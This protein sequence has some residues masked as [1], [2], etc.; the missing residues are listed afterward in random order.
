MII[1]EAVLDD[2]EQLVDVHFSAFSGFFLTSLGRN[3]LI[4]YYKIYI[5]YSHIAFVAEV[6][7]SIEGFVVGSNSS[8]DFYNDLK[9][10]AVC[11]FI[12][13][14]MNIVNIHLFRKIWSRFFSIF[15]KRKVNNSIKA[16]ENLNEL[17]SIGVNQNDKNRGLGS[18]LLA[19]YEDYC[20]RNN[21]S[22]ITLTTDAD[23]NDKVLN[24]YK[25]F[26]YS[27]DQQFAQDHKRNM[28]SL[29]KYFKS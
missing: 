15:L 28:Y 14:L 3:F 25:K 10:E 6:D 17:T 9:K 16:Y 13:I 5:K 8:V 7:N 27:I 21:I 2:L 19:E 1:R 26:G 20:I 24:F 18:K 4:Q 12:P 29:V 23:D 11:F 22:G